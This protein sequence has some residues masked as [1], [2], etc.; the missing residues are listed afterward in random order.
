MQNHESD[1]N[2]SSR[3][4]RLAPTPKA[5]GVPAGARWQKNLLA[6][7]VKGIMIH[8]CSVNQI[9]RRPR[10]RQTGLPRFP[11]NAAH[12]G[13]GLSKGAAM[14]IHGN[15]F[16]D[17]TGMKFSRLTV[18]E[19]AGTNKYQAYLWRVRCDCGKETIVRGAALTTGHTLSCGCFGKE[20]RM[21]SV[22]KH[23]GVLGGYATREYRAWMA[24]KARCHYKGH[25]AFK[26]YGGRGI[27]VCD[28]WRHSFENFRNDM[29][30][31]P[32][33][34][35][36][37]RIDNDKG[38]D[39]SNCKWATFKEQQNN[40]RDNVFIT[41]K[42]KIKTMMEWSNEVGINYKTFSLRIQKWAL[43]RAFNEPIHMECR[44]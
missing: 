7:K 31:C 25:K 17:L 29:G 38:Y 23:G 16:R 27:A 12:A 33:G 2:F 21:R 26:N 28:R 19:E 36:L 6:N 44:A 18:I 8:S 42:G 1:L 4:F 9:C 20:K 30:E 11:A 39:P 34:L 24:M 41:Y 14:T 43:D 37:E 35:M 32:S 40:R 3:H 15:T 22:F 13:D 10:S 5:V